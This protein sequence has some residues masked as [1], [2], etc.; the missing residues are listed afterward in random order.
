MSLYR[1]VQML[2]TRAI[3]D[4]ARV[5][6][7]IAK[8]GAWVLS[9]IDDDRLKYEVAITE[10]GEDLAE[11]KLLATTIELKQDAIASGGFDVEHGPLL[12]LAA[13]ALVEAF[14]WEDEDIT[15]WFGALVLDEEGENLGADVYLEDEE[16]QE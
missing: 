7:G 1:L 10:Q 9:K 6:L 11:L 15:D 16:D 12:G 8:V 4:V 13:N 14:G 5:Q 2:S 3:T